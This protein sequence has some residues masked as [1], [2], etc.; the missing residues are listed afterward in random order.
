[1]IIMLR[2]LLADRFKLV[3][4]TEMRE[5]AVYALVLARSDE[6]LVRI[7]SEVRYEREP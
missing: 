7:A 3:V 5:T 4:H 2:N 6:R 1:M